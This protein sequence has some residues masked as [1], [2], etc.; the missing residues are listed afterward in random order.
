[1]SLWSA[2]VF[3]VPLLG[4]SLALGL[5]DLK[6]RPAAPAPLPTAGW[7]ATAFASFNPPQ[8]D[9]SLAIDGHP[10]TRWTSGVPQAAGQWFELDM[11]KSQTF[12]EITV[13]SGARDAK[14]FMHGY[15]IVVSMDGTTWGSPIAS[16]VGTATLVTV[17]F[18]PVTAR[19]I[20]IVLTAND[21]NINWW[22][23]AE[24]NVL[25]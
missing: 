4:C 1:M 19:Y 23:I 9:P 7:V 2:L 20:Q 5:G 16:G 10:T 13:D 14:D 11:G 3:G 18:P 12:R 17:D 8:N 24:F 15:Q 22:S 6:D 21:V 25:E